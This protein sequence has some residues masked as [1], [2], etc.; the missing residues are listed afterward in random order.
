MATNLIKFQ[1]YQKPSINIVVNLPIHEI[2]DVF[3]RTFQMCIH[4]GWQ[5][6]HVVNASAFVWTDK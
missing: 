6:N 5:I 1:K 3:F 4:L 2:I